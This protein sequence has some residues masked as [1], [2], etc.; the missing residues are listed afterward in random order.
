MEAIKVR[1]L[2]KPGSTPY[3]VYEATLSTGDSYSAGAM[4]EKEFRE[5]AL[6]YEREGVTI[7]S[8]Q[9]LDE[10]DAGEGWKEVVSFEK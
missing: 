7:V 1:G 8:L 4:S 6:R 3:R 10:T 5:A 2:Y 9:C